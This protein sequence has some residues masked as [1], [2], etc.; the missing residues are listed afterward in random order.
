LDKGLAKDSIRLILASLG[1]IYSQAIDDKL[2]THNPTKKL[3]KFYRQAPVRHEEITPLTEDESLLFLKSTL[4][5]ER[6]QY[7]LFLSGLHTGM[8]SGE[9]AGLQWPDIDWNG[10]FIEVR[11]SI[12]NGQVTTMKTENGRRRVDLSD[13]LLETFRDLY[14]QKYEEA[15]RKG[16]NEIPKWVFTNRKG[17]FLDMRN[18]KRRYFKKVL[19]KAGLRS[20]RFHDLRHTFASQ[21]L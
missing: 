19:R 3:G 11:R 15:M 12:V 20:I 5:Y 2:V 13:D 9:L 10:K 17:N 7:P 14:R 8:R 18:V 6:D 21:L 4:E 16:T 1:V